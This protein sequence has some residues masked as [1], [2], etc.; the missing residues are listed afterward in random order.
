MARL[1]LHNATALDAVRGVRPRQTIVIDGAQIA[2]ASDAPAAA[3]P[4]DRVVDLAGRTVMPGLV[5][6]HFHST[7]HE[8]G[9]SPAPLGLDQPPAYLALRAARNLETALLA[10]CTGAVSAGCAHDIDAAMALAIEDGLLRGPRFMPG[11]RDLSTTGHANDSTPWFWKLRAAPAIRL[12]DGADGF[13]RGVREEIKRG[14]E[15]IKLFVTGGHGTRAPKE[16]PEMSRAELCAAV[17]TA[18]DRGRKIRGHIANKAAILMAIDAGLDLIDHADDMDAECI[19]R[20]AAAGTFVAPS[21]L[22][23]HTLAA[24]GPALGFTASMRA[25]VD[26][27]C[28]ML[29]AAN[30]AGVKLLIGDDY[31]AM[32]LPHGGYAAEL[33]F[34]VREAGIAPLDVLRWATVHGAELLGLG[35]RSGQVA[36]GR[37][38]DLLIVDGDPLADISILQDATRLLAVLKDGVLVKDVLPAA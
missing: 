10:G 22:F 7:Y 32:G 6:S 30:A 21:A 34:Y 38:A 11:S 35:D 16:R 17:E 8:L 9:R 2:A 26:R 29:P 36:A 13:R 18:H 31:G 33:A 19:E 1:I 3:G 15:M 25:D 28:H 37:L 27:V 14:A 20:L 24:A 12:C 4:D 5:T 23:P